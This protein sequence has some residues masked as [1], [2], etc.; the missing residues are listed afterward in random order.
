MN[1]ASRMYGL[2]KATLKR[3]L[4]GVNKKAK[5]DVQIVGSEGDLPPE[6][7]SELCQHILEMESRLAFDLA[8]KN[9][10][11]HLFHKEKKT[12]GKKWYYAFMKRHI[13]L[14]LR[15]PRA[16]SMSRATGFN[17]PTVKD[18]FHKLEAVTDKHD[19]KEP[20]RIFNMDET[21]L[22]TVQRKPRKKSLH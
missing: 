18:F 13:R 2:P 17:K 5:G 11:K 3:R 12:A 16:T 10:I 8:K 15:Q 7:E 21:G 20:Q 4:D 22:S 6:L 14:S 9:K 19:I 1:E